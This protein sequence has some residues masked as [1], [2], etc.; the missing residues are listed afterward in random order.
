MNREEIL[1]FI[2]TNP[3]CHLATMEGNQ[4][5]VRGSLSPDIKTMEEYVYESVCVQWK[6]KKKMEYGNS[7]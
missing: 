5:R 2:S 6:P 1:Q 7:P 4:P 3:A